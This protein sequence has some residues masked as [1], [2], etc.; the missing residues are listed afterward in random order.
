MTRTTP[1]LRTIL[2]FG[3]IRLAEALTFMGFL[4]VQIRTSAVRMR[5]AKTDSNSR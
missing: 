2:H 4:L 1:F 5:P 3:Q